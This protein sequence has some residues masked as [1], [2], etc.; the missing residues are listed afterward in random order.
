MH[1]HERGAGDTPLGRAGAEDRKAVPVFM[2]D[3]DGFVG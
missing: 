1:E 2:P 3:L